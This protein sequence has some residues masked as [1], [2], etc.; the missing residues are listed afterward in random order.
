MVYPT[1]TIAEIDQHKAPF[2]GIRV[3]TP[4]VA[5]AVLKIRNEGNRHIAPTKLAQAAHDVANGDFVLNGESLIF[6]DAGNLLDGQHRL[7]AVVAAGKPI[8]SMVAMGMPP[9]TA[10]TVDR[11]KARN[12][13]DVLTRAGYHNGKAL[14]SVARHMLGYDATGGT[15][16]GRNEEFSD[17]EIRDWIDAHPTIQPV[18][19]WAVGLKKQ[20]LGLMSPTQMAL[21]RLI[22]EPKYGAPEV[23]KYLEQVA[24][25][26]GQRGDPAHT[27]H[28]KLRSMRGNASM[29]RTK[30]TNLEGVGIL[31]VGFR[32]FHKGHSLTVIKMPDGLPPI[33]KTARAARAAALGGSSLDDGGALSII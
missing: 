28:R 13:G 29:G 8:T 9:E 18:T 2:T 19:A 25:C 30:L 11:G 4:S 1:L 23:I 14:A 15:G 33:N 10:V 5:A 20:M 22:L 6:S 12:L 17:M 26:E 31:M 7:S 21:A 24:H 3:I 16:F 32:S 27:V